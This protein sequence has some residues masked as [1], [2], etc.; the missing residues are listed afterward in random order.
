MEMISY[1]DKRGQFCREGSPTRLIGC[2]LGIGY[3]SRFR[4]R[5]EHRLTS[6]KCV[7]FGHNMSEWCT[8]E[9]FETMYSLV[10]EAMEH[11]GV[12]KKSPQPEW[13][14]G[15]DQKVSSEAEAVGK[16]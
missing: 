1:W 6:K 16:K 14:N 12:A 8:Y 3:W 15:K 11:A 2:L 9:N 5:H 13:K 10:Y 4:Q 7:Q